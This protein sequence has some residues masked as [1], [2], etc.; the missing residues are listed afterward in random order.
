MFKRFFL[1]L[2]AII[3]PALISMPVAALDSGDIIMSLRPSSQE[4]ELYPGQDYSGVLEV[5]NVGS[6]PFDIEVSVSPYHV[7]DENYEPDFSTETA[8]TKLHNWIT[9]PET[10][11]HIEPSE[12]VYVDFQINTPEDVTGGGQY[13]AIMILAKGADTDSSEA[14]KL[15]TQIAAIIYGHVNGGEMRA[16]GT[17]LD[18]TLPS[19]M[20][21]N[22]F[23]VSQTVENTGNVDFRVTQSMTVNSFFSNREV[24]G[25]NS[26]DE[27]GNPIGTN[28][29]VVLPGTTRTG[30]L[31]WDGA[32]KIG[33]FRVT[34]VIKFLDQEYEY[35]GIVLL[36]PIWLI[37]IIIAV[38]IVL[39][40]SLIFSSKKR[41][42]QHDLA[43]Q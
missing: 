35:S 39:I 24:I 22:N 4:V 11:Y 6:I 12:T 34:Q 43:R 28:I 15:N 20:L 30:I 3:S 37:V 25:P 40:I 2:A 29:A 8:Y 18:Y 19:F 17:L 9:L 21:N 1:I 42:S 38:I 5:S 36:C 33:I 41:K 26:I 27:D 7:A 13:A 16:E 32:P 31:T 23:F 10:Q 14:M